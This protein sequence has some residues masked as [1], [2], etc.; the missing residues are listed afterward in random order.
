MYFS[1]WVFCYFYYIIICEYNMI[2]EIFKDIEGY[3]GKYQVSNLG[4]VK[5]LNYLHTGK[6]RLLKPSKTKKGYLFINIKNKYMAI[7]RLVANAFIDNPLNLPQVNHIDENKEN[8]SIYN[9]EWCDA[10]YNNN[11][12][13]RNVRVSNLLIN[14][15][16][17]SIKIDQFTK[18]GR[19]I[20]TWLSSQEAERNGYQHTHIIKCC[21][22]KRKSH[23]GYIWR[24]HI[25]SEEIN[26]HSFF[27]TFNYIYIYNKIRG[28]VTNLQSYIK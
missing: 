10:K 25:E 1:W 18:D 13:T 11:Y 12:G 20:K 5:S 9:L 14:N 22:N 17:K 6:E 24:Y 2:E 4:R 7:H 23:A 19:F 26:L 28:Y 3:E 21:K 8:N 27:Y 16:Y 15:K